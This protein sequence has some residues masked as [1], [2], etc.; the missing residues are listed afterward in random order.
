MFPAT[1]TDPTQRSVPLH[2]PPPAI[3]THAFPPPPLNPFGSTAP[4]FN[5][6]GSMQSFLLRLLKDNLRGVE[7]NTTAG[8]C[9]TCCCCLLGLRN[10]MPHSLAVIILRVVLGALKTWYDRL[11]VA[12]VAACHARCR[13]ACCDQRKVPVDIESVRAKGGSRRRSFIFVDFNA[14][15]YAGSDVLWAALITKIFDAVS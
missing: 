2:A 15:E 1:L 7:E 10:M 5:V 9:R 13:G 14:W 12:C 11:R 6:D 4:H 8:F 3:C